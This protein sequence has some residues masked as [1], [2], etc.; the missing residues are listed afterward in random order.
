MQANINRG[1]RFERIT[2]YAS[3]ACGLSDYVRTQAPNH[4]NTRVNFKLGDIVQSQIAS[5]T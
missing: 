5:P 4:S 3:K 2:S 1:N